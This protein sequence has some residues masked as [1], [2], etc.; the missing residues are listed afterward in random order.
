[1]YNKVLTFVIGILAVIFV[2]GSDF[3]K[4][5]ENTRFDEIAVYA[6][7]DISRQKTYDGYTV[8]EYIDS[9]KDYKKPTRSIFSSRRQLYVPV[10]NQ[11][12]DLPCGC[13][14]ASAV[15]LI[16]YNGFKMPLTTFADD[17][18]TYDTEFYYDEEE[19][20]WG[21]DPNKV[22]VGDPFGW[23][24]GCY[25]DVLSASINKFFKAIGEA[26]TA[27]P[28][29]G[30]S[31]AELETL[32]SGGVPVIV[33]ATLDMVPF[34]YKKPSVWFF[35]DSGEEFTWYKN[36]HTLV[37]CGY[38]DDTFYF[39][40]PNDKTHLTAYGRELFMTRYNEA[41]TKAVILKRADESKK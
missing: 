9:Y 5:T 30:L 40:D 16:Q 25:P 13:E 15:S 4:K 34:D 33:W 22:F 31:E 18:I 12:P 32:V 29:F 24:Y 35:K 17:Y 37:L 3:N 10:T 39:M 20:L 11:Y 21:P 23:G 2:I 27:H 19:N 38:D 36:S 8:Q 6:A 41:G 28:V 1:M 7:G 26:D 14:I